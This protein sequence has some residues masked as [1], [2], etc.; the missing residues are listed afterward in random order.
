MLKHNARSTFSCYTNLK[1][2]VKLSW[3][4]CRY[5]AHFRARISTQ[6]NCFSVVR[7]QNWPHSIL[8]ELE[9]TVYSSLIFLLPRESRARNRERASRH[10]FGW[11]G[12][13]IISFPRSFANVHASLGSAISRF[14]ANNNAR[15]ADRL[16]IVIKPRPR[17]LPAL[18][19]I[20][21]I[22]N[23]KIGIDGSFARARDS[24]CQN[25]I[26]SKFPAQFFYLL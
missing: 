19:F 1:K 25:N 8:F 24:R 23:P 10:D 15:D 14:F 18:Y 5:R 12:D 9:K 17:Y 16:F 6:D 7:Y 21:C 26:V 2:R 11:V 13:A 22:I 3:K 20:P 4:V